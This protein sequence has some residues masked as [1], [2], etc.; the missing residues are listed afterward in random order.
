MLLPY[1]AGDSLDRAIAKWEATARRRGLAPLP[2][3]TLRRS[4][5]G[6]YGCCRHA[7][8]YLLVRQG[9][10]EEE[11]RRASLLLRLQMF[12]LAR[13]DLQ[14]VQRLDQAERTVLQLARRQLAHKAAKLGGGAG[15]GGAG[16]PP[17]LSLS[18]LAAVRSEIELL[19]SALQQ[20]AEAMSAQLAA[21]QHATAEQTRLLAEQQQQQSHAPP[22]PLPPP[23]LPPPPNEGQRDP[24][25][26]AAHASHPDDEHEPPGARAEAHCS[27]ADGMASA[28]GVLAPSAAAS[29]GFVALEVGRG[30]EFHTF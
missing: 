27:T 17:L 11:C 26:P 7:L 2:A 4:D 14:F 10:S 22:P 24:D 25:L 8:R 5:S 23:P 29:G 15:G 20:A 28:A 16:R 1:L 9:V 6:H 18:Q 21:L 30:A 3:R 19:D 13:H 12:S